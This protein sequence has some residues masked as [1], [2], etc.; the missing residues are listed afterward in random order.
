MAPVCIFCLVKT[1]VTFN[2]ETGN[3]TVTSLGGAG[4]T[5]DPNVDPNDINAQGGI[6]KQAPAD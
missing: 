4:N 3:M 5:S 6:V 2:V 1:H